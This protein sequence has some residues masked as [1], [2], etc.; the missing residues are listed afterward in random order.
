M[1]ILI[2]CYGHE[3]NTFAKKPATLDLFQSSG[4]YLEGDEI[5]SVYRGTP[6]YLGGAIAAAEEAGVTVT[7]SI[8]CLTAAPILDENCAAEMLKKL[9][10]YVEKHKDEIDGIFLSLHGAG[11]SVVCDDLE[12][13]VLTA[14]RAIVGNE[15]PITMSLDLHANLS[16]KNVDLTQGVF[17]IKEYPHVDQGDAGYLATK[18]LISILKEGKRYETVRIPLPMIIPHSAGYTLVE[19]F[20][21]IR[22][23]MKE[24]VKTHNLL[25]ATLFHGFAPADTPNTCSSI[26]VVAES[27]AKEAAEELAQYVWNRRKEIVQTS[28]T[29]EEAMDQAEAVEKE[30]YVVI[31]EL[32]DNPGGGTPGDGTHLLREMLKRN[33]KGTIMGY[34][35]DPEAV[36]EIFRHRIG[37]KISLKL[38]GKTE[39]LHGAPLELSDAEILCMSNGDFISTTPMALGVPGKLGKCARIRVKNTDIIVGSVLKQTFD[40]RPFLVTGAD[41]NQYRYVGLKSTI[42]FRAFFDSRAA[43]IIPADPPG[44]MSGDLRNYDFKKMPRPIFPLDPDAAFEI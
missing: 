21:S 32:S 22:A 26:V 10:F 6:Q 38:G 5:L 7:P 3:A 28:L 2:A 35:Y 31:N 30:G 37:D 14:V 40:D 17:G 11:C 41:I 36:E 18:A 12:T 9:L 1:K 8:S 25:D 13:E 20:P 16:Q 4:A 24:Y 44:L 42:H 27:G 39:P 19:P 15:M 33:R 34:L 23:Y 43:A 29:V